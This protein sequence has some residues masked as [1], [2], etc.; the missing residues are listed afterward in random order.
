MPKEPLNLQCEEWWNILGHG[1]TEYSI[2]R[3]AFW[4]ETKV[5][6]NGIAIRKCVKT[7]AIPVVTCRPS[8][9]II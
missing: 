5:S 4:Y 9:F 1:M 8:L 2:S 3:N 6:K 7:C